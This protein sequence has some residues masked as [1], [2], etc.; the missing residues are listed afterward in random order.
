M[1]LYWL[2]FYQHMPLSLQLC[3]RPPV[4]WLCC[5]FCSVSSLKSP[6]SSGAGRQMKPSKWQTNWATH[7]RSL[8]NRRTRWGRRRFPSHLNL[9]KFYQVEMLSQRRLCS[10]VWLTKA[11]TNRIKRYTVYKKW[12]KIKQLPD[13][14]AML[15]KIK[16]ICSKTYYWNE[17]N[18]LFF[19]P[20]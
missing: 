13:A 12:I 20:H 5:G 14:E 2:F 8:P 15:K 1:L 10:I 4:L 7:P 19:P 3:Y 6:T 9:Y 16:Q 11:N 17:R 18:A